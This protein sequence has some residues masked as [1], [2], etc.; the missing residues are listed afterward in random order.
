MKIREK[1]R[2]S[3]DIR[4]FKKGMKAFWWY[5]FWSCTK[6]NP[7]LHIS[8]SN[9]Y[10]ISD[11]DIHLTKQHTKKYTK[12]VIRWVWQIIYECNPLWFFEWAFLFR[13]IVISHIMGT[14]KMILFFCIINSLHYSASNFL[15][16]LL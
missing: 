9:N 4:H 5:L 8:C 13:P 10:P 14:Q 6:V 16:P 7:C 15:G 1:L 11:K 3:V 2:N 12:K